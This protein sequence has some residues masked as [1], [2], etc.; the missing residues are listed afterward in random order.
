MDDARALVHR[1][2]SGGAWSDPESLG[3]TLASPPA[4]TAWAVDQ[5]QVFAIF[6]DGE[7]W[8][9]YWDGVRWHPWESLGG[10]LTGYA[11]RLVV[12]RRP[13]RCLGARPG[14]HHLASLVGRHPLGRVGAARPLRPALA[15]SLLVATVL[16][17]GCSRFGPQCALTIAAIP[18]GFGAV[19][20]QRLPTDSVILASPADFSPKKAAWGRGTDGAVT[21]TVQMQPEATTRTASYTADHV[22]EPLGIAIDKTIFLVTEITARSPTAA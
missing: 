12:E 14:R 6:D 18:S 11:R 13:H 20:G 10:E 17:A 8:N 2:S 9:R 4:A 1:S 19:E 15:A 3:G 7:L 16:L 5:L 21:V 22:G